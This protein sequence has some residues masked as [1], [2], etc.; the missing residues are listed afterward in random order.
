MT[1]TTSS[2]TASTAASTTADL[3]LPGDDQPDLTGTNPSEVDRAADRA[4]GELGGACSD[5]AR[6]KTIGES[7]ARA[8]RAAMLDTHSNRPQG[9]AYNA[10][11][12][13]WLSKRTFRSIDQS[14]RARL[15]RVMDNLPA[16]EAWRA[17]LSETELRRLNHPSVVWR[18]W[19][20]SNKPTTTSPA[21]SRLKD[22]KVALHA[23]IA[24]LERRLAAGDGNLFTP[25]TS[26]HELARL[27][28]DTFGKRKWRN[29]VIEVEK[30][31]AAR[32][33]A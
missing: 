3:A 7:L 31:I 13:A 11:F 1:L 17:T 28:L 30:L 2:S 23:K 10:A 25:A 20:A 29:V 33:E 15:L 4:W 32:A 22:E 21:R 19:S 6:W 26:A 9:R 12:G 18:K 5:W 8:R 24:E 16:I 27:L 14:D